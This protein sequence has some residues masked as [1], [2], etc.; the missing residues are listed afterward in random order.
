M[1]VV[2]KLTSTRSGTMTLAALAALL[3]GISILVYLNKYRHSVSAEGAPV[4][5]LVAK[6]LIPKG[7][8]GAAIAASGLFTTKTIRESQLRDG[9]L[10]DPVSLGG[11]AAAH[12][13][14]PG[15]QLTVTDFVASAN[16][17]AASLTKSERLISVP[18]DSAH[19]IVGQVQAGDHVDVFAG[20]NVIPVNGNGFPTSGGTG[21]AVLKLI[22]Q[23][24]PVVSVEGKLGSVG[25]AT[26][27]NVT[28]RAT[29]A[30]AENLAF[31][32][33]NGKIWLVLRPAAGAR[34]AK[35]GIVTVETMLLG[36]PPITIVHYLKGGRR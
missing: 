17:A 5:V 19:G 11:R 16:S 28:L 4:T 7:T 33:D 20:F 22:M 12:E 35:P 27:T 2:Q 25:G 23:N 29:P 18:L 31:A 30:Q 36:I 14:Y 24:I 3:A 9:A 10:S 34:V 13:I 1:E 32:S 8:Q 15:Q 26:T 21:H 6:R